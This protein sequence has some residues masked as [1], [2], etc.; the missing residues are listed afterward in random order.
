MSAIR[1][2]NAH[3]TQRRG[4]ADW[5]LHDLRRT[6]ATRMAELGVAPHVVEKLLNHTTGTFGGVA[7]IYNRF[8]YQKEIREALAIWAA[9]LMKVSKAQPKTAWRHAA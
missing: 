1:K 2:A 5:T 7:G 4:I 3:S 6:A 8:E 9:H